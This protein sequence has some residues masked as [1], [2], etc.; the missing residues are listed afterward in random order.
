[1]ERKNEKNIAVAYVRYSDSKQTEQSAEGQLKVI[2][3]YAERNGYV[4]IDEY[5]DRAQTGKTDDRKQFQKMLKDSEKK[6]FDAVIV[7]AIN[8]FGRNARQSLNNAHLLESNNITI[9]SATQEF[10]SSPSGRFFRNITMSND[11]YFSDELAEKTARGMGINADNC[12]S[13]GGPL[14]LGYKRVKI[15]PNNEKS[16]KKYI[17][18]EETSKIVREI[19]TKYADGVSAKEICDSLNERK[20]KTSTGSAFNKNSLTTILRSRKYLGFYIYNGREIP[21]PNMMIINQELFDRVAEKMITNKKAPARAR[22]KAE[23]LLTLKL[24]CGY[25]REMMIGHSCKSK[26]GVTYNYYKCKN[27]GGKKGTC[28]KKMVHK[29]YIEDIVVNKCRDL[30]S[31]QNIIRIAK[32]IVIIAENYD[33]RSE[34]IRLEGLIKE[35]QNAKE[36]HMLSLRKADD[37]VRDMII[38]DL[39]TLGSEIKD[40]EKQL[41]IEYLRRQPITKD[42]V[43]ETLTKLAKGEITDV[44]YR[45][46]L[47]RLLVNKIYL[48]DDKINITF[49]TGDDEI[50]IDDRLLSEIE[51]NLAD[52]EIC[53]LKN[54]GHQLNVKPALKLSARA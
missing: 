18:D 28:K 21:N 46:S 43:A 3:E 47:I 26:H 54:E 49:D 6:Q 39:G 20:L 42:K 37:V 5:I 48:Y 27:Q 34:I 29:E 53:L 19:F 8:R 22:A 14:P 38:A 4:V 35:A 2:Y 36:N 7:Y 31:P 13:N 30:L 9:V 40:L 10:S 12:Y 1:M 50:E 41:K 32:E 51:D 25:C 15:D 24:F 11:Q 45:K 52:Q 33:D 44:A 23:Y 17:V 16:K